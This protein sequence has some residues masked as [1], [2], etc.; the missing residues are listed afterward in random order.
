MQPLALW[1]ALAALWALTHFWLLPLATDRWKAVGLRQKMARAGALVVVE[2]LRDLAAVAATAVAAVIVCVWLAGVF[3]AVSFEAPKAMIDSMASVYQLAK[4]VSESYSEALI[5]FGALAGAVCLYLTARDARQRVSQM[6]VAK[7]QEVRAR[8]IADPAEFDVLRTDAEL[9]PLLAR[10]DEIT[11]ELMA[12]DTADGAADAPVDAPADAPATSPARAAAQQHLAAV[13]WALSVEIASREFDVDAAIATPTE[14]TAARPWWRRA[15]AMIVSERFAKDIGLIKK[16]LSYAATALLVLTLVGWSAEPLA[17]SLQLAVNNL[18]INA[19]AQDAQRDFD[20][21]LSQ[22]SAADEVAPDRA[23]PNAAA[24]QAT[25][26][27]L[28]RAVTSAML[29]TRLIDRLAV[30]ERSAISEAEFVRA[31]VSQQQMPTPLDDTPVARV[32]QETAGDLS[33]A[34][35]SGEVERIEKRVAEELAP[36]VDRL[37]REHSGRFAKLA[38]S[39][40]GRYTAPIKPLDA[41]GKLLATMLEEALGGVDV[42]PSTEVGK[43]AQKLVREFGKEALKTWSQS[44]ARRYV[45]DMLMDAARPHVMYRGTEA[46]AFET[47][48]S[49]RQFAQDLQAAEGRGWTVSAAAQEEARMAQAVAGKVAEAHPEPWVQAQLRERLAGYNELF[50]AHPEEL[51]PTGAGPGSA[52]GGGGG[53]GRN[54]GSPHAEG[55]PH[56][57][58]PVRV[59]QARATSFR[60]ASMSFRVRGVLMGRDMTPQD[61]DIRDIRWRIRGA[62]SAGETSR[63]A[64]EVFGGGVWTRLGAYDAGVVNQALRYAADRR[65]IATTITAGDSKVVSRVTYLHP[66]LVDTPLGCRVVEADRFIDTFT[67]A[68]RASVPPPLAALADN[69]RQVWQWMATVKLA[70]QVAGQA[71]DKACPRD[72]IASVVRRENYASARLSPGIS[73]ALDRFMAAQEQKAS[74]TTAFLRKASACAAQPAE[75]LAG[76]LCRETAPGSLPQAYW[77]PEDHT[78]QFRERQAN[79]TADLAW[80]KPSASHLG[81]VDLWLHTTFALHRQEQQSDAQA[82]ASATA[83]DFPPDNLALLRNVVLD[84]L[85]AYVSLRLDSPSYDEFMAPLEDFL[86]LQRFMRAAFDGVLGREFPLRSLMRLERET[87]PYVTRQPTI[88]WEPAGDETDWRQSLKEADGRA[89]NKYVAWRQDS[90]QRAATRRPTCGAASK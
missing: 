50:P 60:M 63:V 55:G 77:M 47:S 6:W 57:A 37:R 9:A 41:Q 83:V 49:A 54:P 73:G 36:G 84:G 85:P 46:F 56:R 20:K 28:A 52:G 79:A 4:T 69:R 86:L 5:W 58:A 74:G 66:A 30:A 2:K 87:R 75:A 8:L 67:A 82:E 1:T 33:H 23:S 34:A 61:A 10:L 64:I 29:R 21:A 48:D 68:G 39:L 17:D 44:Y 62:A 38:A 70:E 15:A 35:A 81:H 65:V 89:L 14:A 32:R 31:A 19:V 59:A 16:P 88:R 51:P 40:E 71:A 27:A 72:A 26:Q 18:R 53:G 76:C 25:T 22:Q 13:L 42:K 43:Q 45:A 11:A 80:M 90:G 3:S 78:S 7:A 12:M 24:V